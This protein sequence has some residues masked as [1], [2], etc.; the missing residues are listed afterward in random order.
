MGTD[1]PIVAEDEALAQADVLFVPNFG[2]RELFT[3]KLDAWIRT[4]G[5]LVFAMPTVEVVDE[6]SI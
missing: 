6:T 5:R 1:I 4:G 3:K 2:F